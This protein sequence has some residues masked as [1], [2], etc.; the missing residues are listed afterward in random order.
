MK[1]AILDL[2]LNGLPNYIF[3]AEICQVLLRN[4]ENGKVVYEEQ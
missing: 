4:L 1:K 2:E 3:K